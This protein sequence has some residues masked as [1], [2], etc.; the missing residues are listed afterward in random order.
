MN[1]ICGN[2][3]FCFICESD[4]CISNNEN[5]YNKTSIVT[6]TNTS[7]GTS[8][9]VITEPT[10]MDNHQV[11]ETIYIIFFFSLLIIILLILISIVA[12]K[13]VNIQLNVE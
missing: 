13:Y 1:R 11:Q 10:V 8:M 2:L 3:E 5:S 6:T 7:T 9:E 4:K 12:W